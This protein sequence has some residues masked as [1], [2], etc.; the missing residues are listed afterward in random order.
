MSG[1]VARLLIDHKDDREKGTYGSLIKTGWLVLGVQGAIIW[2]VGFVLAPALLPLLKIPA[3][4]H[5]EFVSVL[6]W[7]C[8]YLALSFFTRIFTHILQA[9][10]RTDLCNYFQTLTL[11]LSFGLLWAFFQAGQGVFS[12]VWVNLIGC[13]FTATML[14]LACARLRLFPAH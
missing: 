8:A 12:L 2:A 1:A 10:Q 6:R 11:V 5:T 14:C 4:L 9:H 7:Q 13:L 3:H